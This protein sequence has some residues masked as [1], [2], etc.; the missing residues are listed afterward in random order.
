[1][2]FGRPRGPLD[3]DLTVVRVVNPAGAIP[4]VGDDRGGKRHPF[5]GGIH[6]VGN[7]LQT[8]L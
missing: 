5:Q 4:P 3:D 1:M 2:K 6:L 8:A 7:L